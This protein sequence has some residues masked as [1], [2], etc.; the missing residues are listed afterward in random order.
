MEKHNLLHEFPEYE[1]KI[2]E[3][4]TENT[5]FKK[6][7]EAY[8]E[9]AHEIYKINTDVEQVSDEHSHELKVKLLHLKDELFA[10]LE[11]E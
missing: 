1:A 5:H 10:M 6:L 11:Q 7:F 3:L 9:L 8:D 4:K 2:H